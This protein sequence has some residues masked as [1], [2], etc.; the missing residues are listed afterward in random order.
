MDLRERIEL[1]KQENW[2]DNRTRALI[3]EFSVYNAQV[4]LIIQCVYLV[5]P[6]K[7]IFS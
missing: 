3:A 6:L 7:N 1:L 5:F 2:V 4:N